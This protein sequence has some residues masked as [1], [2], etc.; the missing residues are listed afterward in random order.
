[1]ECFVDQWGKRW[2]AGC[3]HEC[4]ICVWSVHHS[5]SFRHIRVT[6]VFEHIRAALVRPVAAKRRNCG[7]IKYTI[8]FL[9]VFYFMTC[10]FF[11]V[12]WTSK[13]FFYFFGTMF[14]LTAVLIFVFKNEM[15]QV[16]IAEQRKTGFVETETSKSFVES[17]KVIWK[18]LC[19]KPVRELCLILFTSR[20]N[21]TIFTKSLHNILQL[22]TFFLIE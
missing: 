17:Y 6:V 9:L 3:M 18:L 14:L 15:S 16:H 19:L 11:I 13:V 2:L 1:M 10:T 22:I 21:I 20:V 7:S 5:H 12:H 8:I 4:G